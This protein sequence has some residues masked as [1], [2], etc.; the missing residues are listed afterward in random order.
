MKTKAFILL[1]FAANLTFCQPV[2]NFD[3]RI[4]EDVSS[5][6]VLEAPFMVD[7]IIE[8]HKKDSLVVKKT[9]NREVFNRTKYTLYCYNVCADN[10][11]NR[12]I[13]NRNNENRK[14]IDKIISEIDYDKNFVKPKID[15]S[16]VFETC[17]TCPFGE[18]P[19]EMI[20]YFKFSILFMDKDAII[21]MVNDEEGKQWKYVLEDIKFGDAF[22]LNK[23]DNYKQ[24]VLDR[25]MASYIIDRWKEIDIK[26][27]QELIAVYKSIM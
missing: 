27:I 9:F 16:K 24:Y 18:Y 4:V 17:Q 20:F 15:W 21:A 8:I 12:L 1:A 5:I 10:F 22:T 25:R 3:K 14:I 11:Y 6:S 2:E 13:E 19:D 23:E 26:E 7:E